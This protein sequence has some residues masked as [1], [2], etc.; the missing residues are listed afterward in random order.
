MLALAAAQESRPKR[1]AIASASSLVSQRVSDSP[2]PCRLSAIQVPAGLG[3][4]IL[5]EAIARFRPSLQRVSPRGR[6][7]TWTIAAQRVAP[8]PINP[9]ARAFWQMLLAGRSR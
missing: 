1:S 6:A 4:A 3:V 9:A 8:E 5:P 7:W 2:R